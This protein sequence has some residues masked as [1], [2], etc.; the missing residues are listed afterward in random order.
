M[1]T[2]Q[3]EKKKLPV[4]AGYEVHEEIGRGPLGKVYRAVNKKTGTQVVFRGF[5]KPATADDEHWNLAIARFQKVLEAHHKVDAHPNI[6]TLV[7]WG[8][9]GKLF[10]LASEYFRGRPLRAVIDEDGPQ[11]IHAATPIFEQ[12]ATALD[13]AEKRHLAHG[14]ITPYNILVLP[15]SS[16]R[17]INHGLAHTR[18][19]A[20]S[21]YLAPEQVRGDSDDARSDVYGMGVVLY[22]VLSGHLPFQS[23]NVDEL[24]RMIQ[25]QPVPPLPD[26]PDYVNAVLAKLLAKAPVSR[27]TKA[28]D[29]IGDLKRRQAP[30]GVVVAGQVEDE[31]P[32][33]WN[34]GE[35][36]PSLS[37]YVLHEQDFVLAQQRIQYEK[38]LS[39]VGGWLVKAAVLALLVLFGAH[40][41]EQ[42]KQFRYATLAASTGRVDLL[43]D[44]Q[45]TVGDTLAIGE[46]IDGS[47]PCRIRTGKDATATLKMRGAYLKMGPNTV[48]GIR[49]LGYSRG[50]IRSFEL[51]RGTVWCTVGKLRRGGSRF[52]V[53]RGKLKIRVKGT[54]FGVESTSNGA[55]VTTLDGTVQVGG[56]DNKALVAAGEQLL[57]LAGAKLGEAEDMTDEE[58]QAALEAAA[59]ELKQSWLDKI[60]ELAGDFGE[61]TIVSAADLTMGLL[62]KGPEAGA[63][64]GAAVGDVQ[65][66][67]SCRMALI[68]VATSINMF[69]D[70]APEKLSLDLQ[71]ISLEDKDRN[72]ILSAFKD[73]KLTSYKRLSAEKFVLT[74]VANDSKETLMKWADGKVTARTE[75]EEE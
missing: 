65:A 24:A 15:D 7:D 62:G 27:Y 60:G 44:A 66:L 69:D 74:A 13:Q 54:V 17:V 56:G 43:K 53:R 5:H 11:S 61:L 23:D 64:I 32:V 52:E 67:T 45:D 26:Q 35:Q 39:R 38:T 34:Q 72:R 75:D 3:A 12:V 49:H 37:N 50:R 71:E 10:W 58:R 25:Q 16:V 6:Q 48:V 30:A 55:E 31:T 19:R 29:A 51:Q 22:E 28:L 33:P 20:G 57:A 14:D 63:G 8:T 41:L 68:A 2:E 18:N 70:G 73:K 4:I 47:K 46:R 40:A 42:P 21:P 36:T 1:A 59:L 9:D